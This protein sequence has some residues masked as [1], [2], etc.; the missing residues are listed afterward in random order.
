MGGCVPPPEDAEG[1]PHPM[2]RRNSQHYSEAAADQMLG[3]SGRTL[4][5]SEEDQSDE[6]DDAVEESGTEATTEN[7]SDIVE[8]SA[9]SSSA[10]LPQGTSN[11]DRVQTPELTDGGLSPVPRTRASQLAATRGLNIMTDK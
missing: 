8:S 7:D 2:P 11:S 1:Q 4:P 5:V 6:G 10:H 3:L 9:A